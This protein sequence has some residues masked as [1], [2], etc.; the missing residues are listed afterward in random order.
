M[1]PSFDCAA[2]NLLCAEDNSSIFDDDAEYGDGAEEFETAWH[3]RNHRRRNQDRTFNGGELLIGLPVQSDEC[4]AVMI[5][6]ESHH[7]P[8]ADYLTRLRSGDLDIGT[9]QEVVDWITKVCASVS[10]MKFFSFSPFFDFF[11]PDGCGGCFLFE[12]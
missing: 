1:A 2:S 4:L 7:L 3:H 12:R 9:R 11:F 8:A 10:A 5:E 6:K